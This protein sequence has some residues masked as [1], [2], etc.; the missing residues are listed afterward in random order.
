VVEVDQ[1]NQ[2]VTLRWCQE[3][4]SWRWPMSHIRLA[5]MLREERH[6]LRTREEFRVCHPGEEGEDFRVVLLEGGF[7]H[8]VKHTDVPKDL[9]DPLCRPI[10]RQKKAL[11]VDLD[12]V[13]L[14]DLPCV[15][16]KPPRLDQEDRRANEYRTSTQSRS[17]L[18]RVVQTH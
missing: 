8:V 15:G 13:V 10:M 18:V 5:S 12:V 11:N 4:V 16:L 17:A 1:Q 2:L 3:L 6:C 7:L 9:P 14:G